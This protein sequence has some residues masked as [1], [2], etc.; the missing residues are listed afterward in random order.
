MAPAPE[1]PGPRA[2]REPGAARL[3]R[4]GS[5][6]PLRDVI[7]AHPRI[8]FVGINPSLHSER[9]GHHFAGPGN[10]FWRLLHAAGLVPLALSYAEDQRLA[11]FGLALT[12]LCPRASATAAELTRD[13]IQRGKAALRRKISRLTPQMV[14][15]VGL[16][17]YQ[18]FFSKPK[19]GGAGPKP[20]TIDSARVF[21][22]PNPSGRNANYPGFKD[23]LIWF[24]RLREFLEGKA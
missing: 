8:L 21:V 17:V 20:E 18:Q 12:N 13:E 7:G 16:T 14:V 3:R 24:Q 1:E 5:P 19:S 10:P 23:K 6:M 11:E 4:R 2:R 15:F 22:I 9:L